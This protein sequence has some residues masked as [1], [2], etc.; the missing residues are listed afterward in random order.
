MESEELKK[1]T[2]F[3]KMGIYKKFTNTRISLFYRCILCRRGKVRSDNDMKIFYK[4]RGHTPHCESRGMHENNKVVVKEID[5]K[6]ARANSLV[7]S[8]FENNE[9]GVEIERRNRNLK[10]DLSSLNVNSPFSI[11]DINSTKFK[12][13][14]TNL[15]ICVFKISKVKDDEI[16]K[17]QNSFNGALRKRNYFFSEDLIFPKGKLNIPV[18]YLSQVQTISQLNEEIF[19]TFKKRCREKIYAP[20]IIEYD[21]NQGFYVKATNTIP[22]L[23]LICEYSGSVIKYDQEEMKEEDSLMDYASIGNKDY[24]IS[25]NKYCNLARFISGINNTKRRGSKNVET[26]KFQLNGLIH[27]I[28]YAKRPIFA[29]EILQYDYNGGALREYDTSLFA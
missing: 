16:E 15:N 1:E 2:F 13:R 5:P 25:P 22:A 12:P 14:K 28:L 26:I 3:L 6:T 27:V 20:L 10:E 24:V 17:F 9:W 11:S 23:S 8:E 19:Q 18:Y 7:G 21:T 29:D 4:V